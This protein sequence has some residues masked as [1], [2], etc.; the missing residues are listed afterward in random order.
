MNWGAILPPWSAELKLSAE[1]AKP[2]AKGATLPG[3]EGK[4]A[5]A[6]K[7]EGDVKSTGE[8]KDGRS[9]ETPG[10]YPQFGIPAGDSTAIQKP[11]YEAGSGPRPGTGRC[12]KRQRHRLCKC[13]A[14]FRS[15]ASASR[16]KRAGG[17][18]AFCEGSFLLGIIIFIP[19]K[20]KHLQPC[21][22][23][24]MAHTPSWQRAGSD[25]SRSGARPVV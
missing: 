23:G 22:I 15:P 17:R 11:L 21:F 10:L 12:S 20:R 18:F 24:S 16:L 5:L 19:L 25:R 13:V 8:P 9:L 3:E 2:A 1:R 14:P 7:G 4:A 6:S